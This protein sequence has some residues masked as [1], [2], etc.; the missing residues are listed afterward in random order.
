MATTM[1]AVVDAKKPDI[2]PDRLAT[3][4]ASLE[5]PKLTGEEMIACSPLHID[6]AFWFPFVAY[7]CYHGEWWTL[8]FLVLEPLITYTMCK[9][10]STPGDPTNAANNLIPVDLRPDYSA[11][12]EVIEATTP[13]SSLSVLAFRLGLGAHPAACYPAHYDPAL[14]S[15]PA[16]RR[17]PHASC[18]ARPLPA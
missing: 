13:D 18:S 4:K 10:L 9:K 12:P 5:K 14:L 3:E 15:I 7:Q 11:S 8:A 6:E 1:G 17:L 16:R 2:D